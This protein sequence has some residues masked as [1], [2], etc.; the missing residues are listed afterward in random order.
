MYRFYR[1]HYAAERNPLTNAAVYA[2]IAG[3]LGVSA[4]RSATGRL[5]DRLS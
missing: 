5:A 3:K 2:G 1:D 4:I